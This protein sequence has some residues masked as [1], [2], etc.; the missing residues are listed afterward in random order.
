MT[1]TNSLISCQLITKTTWKCNTVSFGPV[2]QLWFAT[3]KGKGDSKPQSC[4]QHHKLLKLARNATNGNKHLN[5]ASKQ[6]FANI[7]LQISNKYTLG[8]LSHWKIC[9]KVF[10]IRK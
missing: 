2:C 5:E 3:F 9:F 4:V 7:L 6:T 1:N 10:N 8:R